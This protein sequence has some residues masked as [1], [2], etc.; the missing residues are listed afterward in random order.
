MACEI[1]YEVDGEPAAEI[2]DGDGRTL[3]ILPGDDETPREFSRESALRGLDRAA[4]RVN[5][6][7]GDDWDGVWR[8]GPNPELIG[9]EV[10]DA[11]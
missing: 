4:A 6:L 9:E 5:D 11:R 7:F 3:S 10:A 1:P 8:M 2:A